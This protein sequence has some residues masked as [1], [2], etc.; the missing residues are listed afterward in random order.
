MNDKL[1]TIFL[2]GRLA[3]HK[4]SYPYKKVNFLRIYSLYVIK[5]R[6]SLEQ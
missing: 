6:T 5:D 3:K 1:T 2:V 4:S